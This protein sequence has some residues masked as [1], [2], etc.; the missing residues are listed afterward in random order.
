MNPTAFAAPEINAF[1]V[2]E[3]RTLAAMARRLGKNDDATAWQAIADELAVAINEWLLEPETRTYQD[4]HLETGEFTGMISLACFIPVYAG[5]AP[6]D[7][8][9]HLCRDYLLSPDH[10]LTDL[11]F[12][13]IDRAH[14]TFRNGGFLTSSPEYPDSLGQ[15]SYWRGRTWI[16]GDTWCLGALWQS[17]FR[18]EADALADRILTAVNR[19]EG[20]CECYDSLTG[21]GNG[22]PEFMWSSA[23]VLLLA[24]GFYRQASVA[25]VNDV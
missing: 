3:C 14:P 25:E 8:A 20:I 19:S 16:H 21:F 10:F 6:P 4:R 1:I 5:I 7:V 18:Q 13:V 12:P 22:H 9:T 23:A 17:G 15:Q 24:H 2:L 11:P